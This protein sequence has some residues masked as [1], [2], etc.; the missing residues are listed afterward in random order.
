MQ[1]VRAGGCVEGEDV[2]AAVEKVHC[3]CKSTYKLTLKSCVS[4]CVC[5]RVYKRL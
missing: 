1:E 4:V 2:E 3:Q 5:H